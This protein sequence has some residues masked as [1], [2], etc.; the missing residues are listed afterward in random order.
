MQN[1]AISML[2]STH[3]ELSGPPLEAALVGFR[4]RWLKIAPRPPLKQQDCNLIAI[5]NEGNL[6]I[7]AVFG[8]FALADYKRFE[9]EVTN[10]LQSQ[11]RVN[12]LVDLRDMVD[13]TVDVALEDIRFTRAHAH[14][15]GRIAILSERE[16]VRWIALLSQLFLDADIQVFSDEPA[17]REWLAGD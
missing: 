14:E 2:W 13:Y 16:T 7:V 12:L 6:G 8:E 15:R 17:A 10:Q 9:E 5:Q 4:M 3:A 11:G 1:S